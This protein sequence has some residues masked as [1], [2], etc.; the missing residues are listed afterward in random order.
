MITIRL[1]MNGESPKMAPV[2]GLRSGAP[3]GSV[4]STIS[5][6]TPSRPSTRPAQPARLGGRR[7]LAGA[8]GS[9]G[10]S[11][12]VGASAGSY[13]AQPRLDD[14]LGDERDAAKVS[15]TVGPDA[16]AQVGGQVDRLARVDQVDGLVGDLGEHAVERRDQDVDAERRADAGE[17][18]RDARPADGGRRC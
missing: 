9:S 12:P 13:G 8:S 10:R 5:A 2:S 6:I 1:S 7:D 16:E 14:P 3:G 4:S 17:G 18:R 15:T 11:S